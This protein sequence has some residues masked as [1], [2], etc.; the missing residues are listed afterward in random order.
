MFDPVAVKAE[1]GFII[2]ESYSSEE[3]MEIGFMTKLYS[4]YYEC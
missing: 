1:F 2:I 3:I 4:N